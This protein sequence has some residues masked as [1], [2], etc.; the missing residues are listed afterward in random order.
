MVEFVV[1]VVYIL[2]IIRREQYE[3]KLYSVFPIFHF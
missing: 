2:Y 3:C 1:V